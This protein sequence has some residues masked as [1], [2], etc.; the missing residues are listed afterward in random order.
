MVLNALGAVTLRQNPKFHLLTVSWISVPQ[1]PVDSSGNKVGSF[2]GINKSESKVT[3]KAR[4]GLKDSRTVIIVQPGGLAV[5]ADA[6]VSKDTLTISLSEWEASGVIEEQLKESYLAYPRDFKALPKGLLGEPYASRVDS[7]ELE[8]SQ[9]VLRQSKQLSPEMLAKANSLYAKYS[10]VETELE[11]AESLEDVGDVSELL[12]P[13]NLAE[14]EAFTQ[15][16]KS[17]SD[18]VRLRRELLEAHLQ[19]PVGHLK[20]LPRELVTSYYEQFDK[21]AKAVEKDASYA[22]LVDTFKDEESLP[23]EPSSESAEPAPKAQARRRR[24]RKT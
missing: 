3:I 8:I 20:H 22:S 6:T 10:K 4:S 1:V 17:S 14:V 24:S 16:N 21:R 11:N 15:L 2:V 13:E 9:A 5:I 7:L 12:S 18:D 19:M 23:V